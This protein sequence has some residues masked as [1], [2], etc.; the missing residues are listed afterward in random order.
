MLSSFSLYK[1]KN[2][3]TFRLPDSLNVARGMGRVWALVL[4]NKI[5]IRVK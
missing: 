4:L 1:S 2:P 5:T 3:L